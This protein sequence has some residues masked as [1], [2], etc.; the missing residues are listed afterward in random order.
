[1]GITAIVLILSILYA[2][3]IRKLE[4]K[5]MF[6]I[7]YY[8]SNRDFK[9]FKECLHPLKQACGMGIDMIYDYDG[10]L[11]TYL[12]KMEYICSYARPGT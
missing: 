6:L 8:A 2:K 5:N 3:M 4:R 1:M 12:L 9:K 11:R 7:V 10:R